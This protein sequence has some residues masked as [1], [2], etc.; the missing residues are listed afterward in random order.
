MIETLIV[1][2]FVSTIQHGYDMIVI[3][4]KLCNYIAITLMRQI[5]NEKLIR[6]FGEMSYDF[7]CEISKF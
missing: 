4:L 6:C 1:S 2:A 3:S 7:F 5:Y